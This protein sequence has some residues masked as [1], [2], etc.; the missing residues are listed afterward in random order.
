MRKP[1]F[2]IENDE[3]GQ[4]VQM[5]DGFAEL[6]SFRRNV[7]RA[8]SANEITEPKCYRFAEINRLGH[9]TGRTTRWQ[10]RPFNA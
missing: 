1:R 10:A 3:T 4:L 9:Y 7:E 2:R 6:D 8:V 5:A